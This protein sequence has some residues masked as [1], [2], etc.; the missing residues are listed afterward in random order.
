VEAA[1]V[2]A[3][4]TAKSREKAA[5]QDLAIRLDDQGGDDT[6]HVRAGI[7]GHIERAVGVDPANPATSCVAKPAAEHREVAADHDLAV[8]L[9]GNG[10]NPEIRAWIEGVERGL[11]L[12]DAVAEA[13]GRHQRRDQRCPSLLEQCHGRG[14]H[15]ALALGLESGDDAI[16]PA[17]HSAAGVNLPLAAFTSEIAEEWTKSVRAPSAEAA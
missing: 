5:D 8:R 11:C 9:Y 4:E 17:R 3:G 14:G 1:N 2:T 10:P 12:G 16:P 13:N 7:E 15:F 6:V